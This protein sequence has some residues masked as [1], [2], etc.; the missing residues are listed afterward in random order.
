MTAP[1]RTIALT[2]SYE[3][4]GFAGWQRQPGGR[5]VQAV[6]E[7]VLAVIDE[8]PVTAIAAGRTD[9]GVHALGQ[10]V[11][12]EVRNHL[13]PDVL[14]RAIN[15]RL[16]EDVRVLSATDAPSGFDARR[17]ARA[18]VYRYT[19][20]LGADPGPFVR[21]VVWHIPQRLN[22]AAM[23]EAAAALVGE[24][25]FGA[26]QAAGG[27]LR[28][29]VRRLSKSVL[30][31]EPGTPRYLRYQVTGSGFLRHMV[32]NIVGTLVD[33]G[34]HRWPPEEIAAIV[35][36]RSRQRAGPTAPPQGLV[37]VKVL[38]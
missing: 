27:D 16:P 11:S 32:R 8:Q 38:Y 2:L 10:V 5:T 20:A 35:A 25:D 28:S 26:F 36:S 6:I 19:M 23:Q 12:A 37:L 13:P 14:V 33:I 30:I 24:H 31:D 17:D 3:G 29:S 4:T 21:R 18:K 34:K 1:A 9:A 22:V 7:D 15:V